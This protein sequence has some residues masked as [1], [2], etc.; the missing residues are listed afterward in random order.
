[1]ID[2]WWCYVSLYAVWYVAELALSIQ[3][4]SF[5]LHDV[6]INYFYLLARLACAHKAQ[7]TKSSSIVSIDLALSRTFGPKELV[8][9]AQAF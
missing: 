4:S 3:S 2:D 5:I 1:M 8:K 6:I 7:S 9:H